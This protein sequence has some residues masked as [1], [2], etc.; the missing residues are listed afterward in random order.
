MKGIRRYKRW[1]AMTLIFMLAIGS[2]SHGEVS[3]ADPEALDQKQENKTGNVWVSYDYPRFQTFTPEITGSLS[4]IELNIFDTVAPGALKVKIYKDGDLSTLLAEA[5][6]ASFSAGWVSVNFSG[7]SPYLQKGTMYRMVASTEFG[8]SAGFGWYGSTG[9]PYSRGYSSANNY[10]FSFRT[11]MIADDSTSP[12]LSEIS[13]AES[14]IVADGMSQTAVTVKLKDAQGNGLT[15][16]GA[17]V[18]ITSTSGSVSAVTDNH[19]GTYTAMLT[20][21]VAVGTATVSATVGGTALGGTAT[22]QFVPG[23]SSSANSTIAVGNSSLTADGTSQTVVT[24]KLKD[25]QGNGLSAGG[26]TVV[27]TS[28]SGTVSAV[29]DNHN[30]A[31]TAMLT[32][33]TTVGTA[34]VS[35]SVDGSALPGTATVQFV[36]GAPSSANSTIAVGDSSLTADGTSQTVVTVKLK[37]AQGNGLSAGGATVVITSTSGTVSS[38]TDNHN[39]TYTAMLTAPVSVGTASVSATV[40][41][42]ALGGTATVQFVPGAPSS[43]NS[44]IAVG[45]SSLTA[46]GTS[47]TAVTVKLKDAQ[48]NGLSAGGATVVITS[49]SGTVSSVTD[50]HNGTYTAMLTAPVV[51]GTA[52]VSATV[53]G[54]ALGGTATIQFVPGA[55]SSANSTIAVGNSSLTADG[56]SQTAV[57]VKLKDAQGNALTT[58][59]ATVVITSTSGS[60]STVADNHNGTY[61]ATLTAPVAVGTATVSATVGGTAL[62]GTATVQFVPG[63]PSSANST[64][65]VGNSSLTADGTSQTVVTV[66]LKDAHGNGLSAGGETV[67]I[68]ST[69]GSVSTVTDNHNGTYTA[70]LTA[71]VTVGTATV[72]ATVG[73]TALGGTAPVQFVP[74]AP[75]S[76]N[77]TIAVGNS[78]LTADGTSQTAV[79][80]K[81]KDAQGNALTTGGATVV[82][83]STSG[84]VST[85]ADNH[86][87]TYT[88]MLTAPVTVGTATVSAS[89]DGNALTGTATVQFVAG[90]F[91]TETGIIAAGDFSLIADGTSQTVITVKLKDAQGNAL[92]TGGAVVLI[93]STS[94]T[95]STVTD[96]HNGTYT[97]TL[98]A[99]T[100]VGTAKISASADGSMLASTVTVQLVPGEVSASHSTITASSLVVRADGQSQSLISVKLKD[101][102]DHPL[103]GKLVRLQAQAGSSVITEVYG[104]SVTKEVYGLTNAEGLAT[105]AVNNVVAEKVTYSAIEEASGTTLD[106]TVNITFTYDQPPVI[107]LNMDQAEPT[108]GSVN[109][110]VTASVYGEFNQVS[111]IKWAAGSRSISYFDTQGTEISDHFTV[112]ENGIYSVYVADKAGNANVS[113]IEIRNI[114]PLSSNADLKVWQLIGLGGTVKFDFDPEKSSSSLEVSHPVYGLKMLLTPAD[115]YSAVYVNELQVDSHSITREYVLATG[116]NKFEVRVKAQDDSMKTYTLNVTRLADSKPDSTPAPAP[117]STPVPIPVPAAPSNPPS[118]SN[119]PSPDKMPVVRVNDQKVTGIVTVQ[120]DTNGAKS[121]DALLNLDH[122][123]QVIDSLP[124]AAEANL[125]ISIEEGADNLALRLSGDTVPILAGKVATITFV[126]QYGRY[127][128]P[129]NEIV[130]RES[131]WTKDM[132]VRLLMG[133]GPAEEGL[134]KAANAGGYQLVTD[135]VHFTV[136][137]KRNGETEEVSSFNHFVERVIYLPLDAGAASTAVVWDQN[138]GVRPVPTTFI[139][140]DGHRSAVIR[141]LTNSTYAVIYRTFNFTDIQGH[142]AENEIASMNSRLIVRGTAGSEFAP[143]AMLPGLNSLQCW[144]GHLGCRNEGIQR[145]TST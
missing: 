74:G 11:Y 104:N 13:T 105:F 51:V 92:T 10:D 37:D 25:A 12:A 103:A 40:G 35:A 57:T 142:W 3:A 144:Q 87:G 136:Q 117:T 64:I 38:V 6:L 15:T 34:T 127:R 120:T 106:Q 126:T 112:Q 66:K 114:V 85:V 121:I 54:T 50:N 44:T 84:S 56:T 4:R 16:G 143:E 90:A 116:Q 83:K 141:S 47:Q 60:V 18:V 135:P 33:P 122:L 20:A 2:L 109:V 21:P 113:L 75:S 118:S 82:I 67:V 94:G 145:V 71:P 14:S 111:S 99:P 63:A 53:G 59:G 128:L 65:A 8:G 137:I 80:V 124:I 95:M 55:P 140:V 107:E 61:T 77:S 123:R 72:S 27:I 100:A 93:T 97:A 1:I 46:D 43:T 41:G 22:V 76:A 45:N 73:G 139:T 48:G 88:A 23:A 31:Y 32:A 130:N 131:D 102:Y 115:V 134:Q 86:N 138:A 17:T 70:M 81:L 5:Q 26:E 110:A 28:T 89:V 62:G 52:T 101:G 39:G 96:N 49:T 133:H 78:S 19:N 132:E 9:N 7:A 119:P 24:V 42:T 79:T 108:F 58:G 98:T 129:L 125:S 29:T 68:T 36:P 69:S 30:G 91:S